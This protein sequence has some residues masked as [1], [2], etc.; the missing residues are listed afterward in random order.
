MK[1][2]KEPFIIPIDTDR[3]SC[4]TCKGTG[5]IKNQKCPEC[6]GSG[7]AYKI[8]LLDNKLNAVKG[9]PQKQ[10]EIIVRDLDQNKIIYRNKGLGGVTSIMEEMDKFS[11]SSIEGKYQTVMWG[12]PLVQRFAIDRLEESF[13]NA[14]EEYLDALETAGMFFTNRKQIREMM[15]KGNY[16]KL[17]QIM[18]AIIDKDNPKVDERRLG[19]NLIKK[20]NEPSDKTTESLISE[21]RQTLIEDREYAVITVK[22]NGN[23]QVSKDFAQKVE[24]LTKGMSIK[25]VLLSILESVVCALAHSQDK[26]NLGSIEKF[27]RMLSLLKD[28]ADNISSVAKREIARKDEELNNNQTNN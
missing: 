15:I 13:A 1:T 16:L 9:V 12:H 20:V 14:I 8:N 19:E 21:I 23:A 5:K 22:N 18:E 10:Y 4:L 17:Q 27:S 11:A 6:G 26:Q 25:Q 28:L 2:K 3:V 24:I 7:S